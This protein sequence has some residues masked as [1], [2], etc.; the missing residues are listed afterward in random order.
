M[1]INS[2]HLRQFIIRSTL[3]EFDLHSE[4]AENLLMGTAAQE[5]LLGTFLRQN[6][7]G[8]DGKGAALGIF[9]MESKTHMDIWLNFITYKKELAKKINNTFSYHGLHPPATDIVFNLKYAALM[10][11]LHYLRFPEALP[12]SN[13]ISGLA[14]YWKKYYNTSEGKG[15]IAEFINNYKKYVL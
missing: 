4:S 12:D 3:I 15:T 11:R 2:K 6:L 10:C 9:G 8:L 7:K 1:G 14:N 5:T 13:D